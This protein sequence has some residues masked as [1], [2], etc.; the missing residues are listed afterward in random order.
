MFIL[1]VTL[2]KASI[3]PKNNNLGGYIPA[4]KTTI[5]GGR[6]LVELYQRQGL[7]H[8]RHADYEAGDTATV[9]VRQ[10]ALS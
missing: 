5:P 9:V 4:L 1:Y 2:L 10:T 7:C 3:G 8:R 6:G